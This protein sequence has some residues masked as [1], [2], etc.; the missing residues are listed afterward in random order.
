MKTRKA[1]TCTC[2]LNDVNYRIYSDTCK[3]HNPKLQHTPT[4]WAVSSRGLICTNDLQTVIAI[5]PA[6]GKSDFKAD[7][8]FIV[9]AV[10]AYDYLKKSNQTLFERTQNLEKRL[11]T[12][13]DSHEEL[14]EAVKIALE[15][16]DPQNHPKDIR[17]QVA[18]REHQREVFKQAIAKAEEK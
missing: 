5:E 7:A 16:L 13:K 18:F 1:E 6:Y 10:N 12:L 9:R 11:D 4:P 8:A 17:A 15:Y 3:K 2:S 14:L